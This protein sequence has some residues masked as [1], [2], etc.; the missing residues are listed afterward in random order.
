MRD[1][2]E[3]PTVCSEAMR[4]GTFVER[5]SSRSGAAGVAPAAA[6]CDAWGDEEA[7]GETRASGREEE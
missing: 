7:S 4:D 2:D 1:H 3:M 5:W 6:G